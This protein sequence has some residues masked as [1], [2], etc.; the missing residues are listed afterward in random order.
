[1]RDDEQ[2]RPDGSSVHPDAGAP[3]ERFSWMKAGEVFFLFVAAAAALFTL[4]RPRTE[5]PPPDPNAPVAVAFN[6]RLETADVPVVVTYSA[7]WCGACRSLKAVQGE[8]P[9]R[10]AGALAFETIDVDDE[11]QLASNRNVS[12]L[13]TQEIWFR[14]KLVQRNVGVKSSTYYDKLFAHYA[15]FAHKPLAECRTFGRDKP[16]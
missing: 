3:V 7:V 8:Y 5:F 2:L 4:M 16:C 9:E 14:G 15:R 11:P 12:S 10:Y 13:P 6:E 1:M